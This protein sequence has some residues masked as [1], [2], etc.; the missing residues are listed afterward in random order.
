MRWPCPGWVDIHTGGA[1]PPVAA[2]MFSHRV[3][4]SR[5]LKPAWAMRS[6]PITSE[7]PHQLLATGGL[8]AGGAGEYR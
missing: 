2:C 7:Y 6:R 3:T 5:G 1:P 4:L 8:H